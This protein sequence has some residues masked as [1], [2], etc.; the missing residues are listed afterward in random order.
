[1]LRVGPPGS[2]EG[3]MYKVL[4]LSYWKDE[5]AV[6]LSTETG[7]TATEQVWVENQEFGMKWQE[8]VWA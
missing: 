1:M 5:V 4:D 6:N 3:V 2:P 8:E 7:K